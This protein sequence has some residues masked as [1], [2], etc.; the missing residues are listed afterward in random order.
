[1]CAAQIDRIV[2]RCEEN[3][4]LTQRDMAN[5]TRELGNRMQDECQLANFVAISID[6]FQLIEP[7]KPL[8]GNDV[9]DK[10]PAIIEDIANAGRCLGFGCDTAAMFHLMR[11]MEAGVQKFGDKLGVVLTDEKTWQTILDQINPKIKALGKDPLAKRYSSIATHLYHVK[12]AWRNET[13]HPK[14]TY[15][16]DEAKVVFAAVRSFMIDLVT[17]L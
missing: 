17:A 16:E 13:M 14:A 5:M 11:V 2:F 7:P 3:K 8:F 1:M 9:E 6:L 4:L 15:T 10:L 12:L